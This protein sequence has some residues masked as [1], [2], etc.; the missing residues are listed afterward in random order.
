MLA[1]SELGFICGDFDSRGYGVVTGCEGKVKRFQILYHGHGCRIMMASHRG[2]E[3]EPVYRP[4]HV[5]SL[6]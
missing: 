4:C 6:I 1:L 2:V 3:A 5:A